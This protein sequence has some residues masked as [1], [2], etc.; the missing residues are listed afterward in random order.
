M[1]L[2]EKTTR[3]DHKETARYSEETEML[4]IYKINMEKKEKYFSFLAVVVLTAFL[5]TVGEIAI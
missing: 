2:W 3:I 5:W 4:R 1:L